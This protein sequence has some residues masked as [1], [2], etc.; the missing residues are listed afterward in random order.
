[1]GAAVSNHRNLFSRELAYYEAHKPQWLTSHLGDFVIVC[2][3][4]LGG[5]FPSYEGAL[6]GGIGQF[7][8]GS[9]FLIK[10]IL[11]HEPVFAIY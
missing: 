7:G 6:R 9:E 2:G 4:N 5:F 11:E 3:E 1:M 8:I 10:Q